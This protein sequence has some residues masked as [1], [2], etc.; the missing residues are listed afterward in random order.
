MKKHFDDDQIV[1]EIYKIL[2]NKYARRMPPS[3][4]VM[5]AIREVDPPDRV[6]RR[7]WRVIEDAPLLPPINNPIGLAP[8][9]VDLQRDIYTVK[10]HDHFLILWHG[11]G[12]ETIYFARMWGNKVPDPPDRDMPE[13]FR[14]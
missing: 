1:H 8:S 13:V 6:D 7:V 10:D 3:L 11:A 5:S 9:W 4:V 12:K 14:K 2:A